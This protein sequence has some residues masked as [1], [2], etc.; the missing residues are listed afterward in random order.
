MRL[1]RLSVLML[2]VAVALAALAPDAAGAAGA[3]PGA[4][5]PEVELAS[6][7]VELDGHVLFRVV[8]LTS[9][10]AERRAAA[11]RGRIEALARDRSFQPAALTI[12]DAETHLAIMAG[13]QQVMGIAPEDARLERVSPKL[14]AKVYRDR[15]EA[16]VEEYRHDRS[17]EALGRDG[18]YALG[19]TGALVALALAVIWLTRR[20]DALITRKIGGHIQSLERESFQLLRAQRLWGMVHFAVRVLRALALVGLALAYLHF[21][22]RLFPWTR[23]AA[24]RLFDLVTGP[25][26]TMGLAVAGQIPNLIFLVILFFVMRFA[27]RLTRLFFDAVKAGS[28][29]LS[30][31]K[32]EWAPPTYHIARVAIVAFTLVV[33]YPYIPGS[34]SAA[35][36][37][38]SIFIGVLLS[39]GGSSVIAN[40]ISGYLL[41][42]RGALAPGDRVKIGDVTGDVIEVR[43]QVTRLRSLK[44]EEVIVPNSEILSNKIVNYSRFAREQGLILHTTVGI[45]YE[46]PWRQVE[47]ILLTAADRTPGLLKDPRP[48]VRQQR[49]GDFAVDYEIN[50]YCSDAQAMMEL[51]TELHRNILDGFNQYGI[52]IMTPAYRGDPEQPKIVPKEQWYAAPA[53]PEASPR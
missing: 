28:V 38:I 51:Y 42:Y 21:V 47:A 10:P 9:F 25:V 2:G 17:P 7:P 5:L 22:L 11:I 14:L 40:M 24:N 20:L 18:V 33:A 13:D 8:G 48:F 45:G 4:T 34:G 37:G 39:L 29:S 31:F 26:T 53:P 23:G 35:F 6:A 46:T 50:V 1:E 16:A 36:Q 44:N 32:P 3:P 43:T 15:I 52:Q 12:V 19:A 27:L 41:V 30:G 49:L